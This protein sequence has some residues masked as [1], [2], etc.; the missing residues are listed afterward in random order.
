LG[1]SING[2]DTERLRLILLHQVNL[3]VPYVPHFLNSFNIESKRYHQNKA[4]GQYRII[5]PKREL[6]KVQQPVKA[7][8][9]SSVAFVLGFNR[10]WRL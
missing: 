2:T 3:K 5:I 8:I 9:P 10:G 4:K 7:H 1:I 6:P